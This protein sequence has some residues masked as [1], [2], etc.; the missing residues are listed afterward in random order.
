MIVLRYFLLVILFYSTTLSV[1]AQ[2]WDRPASLDEEKR[3][4]RAAAGVGYELN[5][6]LFQGVD[7]SLEYESY[8][9][10]IRYYWG[11]EYPLINLLNITS[12][13]LRDI[14][15]FGLLYYI[16]PHELVR[17][18]FGLASTRGNAR[19]E[20]IDVEVSGSRTFYWNEDIRYRAVT[21]S[22][23][24]TLSFYEYKNLGF[25]AFFRGE[26][27]PRRLYGVVGL[28]I[29]LFLPY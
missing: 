5:H 25:D 24:A 2:R 10:G 13:P 18:G 7:V 15:S 8:A 17:I 3:F 27:A 12:Y 16:K 21:M 4:F 20:L 11:Q 19:G 23:D 29:S 14:Q 1:M 22:L 28:G 9:I 6:G 26:L